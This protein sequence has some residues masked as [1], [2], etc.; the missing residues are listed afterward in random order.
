MRVL[1]LTAL[2]QL[3]LI[4]T[5]GVLLDTLVVRTLLVPALSLDIGPRVWWPSALGRPTT[6]TPA[7]TG[8]PEDP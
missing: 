1:P 8:N 6:T 4:V 5:V 2:L 7:T 3:G